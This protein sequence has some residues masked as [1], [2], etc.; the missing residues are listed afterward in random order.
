MIVS[1]P[2]PSIR[3]GA[4]VGATC[5]VSMAVGELSVLTWRTAVPWEIAA[6]IVVLDIGIL[7]TVGVFAARLSRRFSSM[8]LFVAAATMSAVIYPAAAGTL[9]RAAFAR[10]ALTWTWLPVAT[11]GSALGIAIVAGALTAAVLRVFIPT[12]ELQA[13]WQPWGLGCLVCVLAA[14]L[15]SLAGALHLRPLLSFRA[16]GIILLLILGS[17]AALQLLLSLWRFAPQRVTYGAPALALGV[18]SLLNL[19][20]PASL[21]RGPARP[22]ALSSLHEADG[23]HRPNIILI[24]LDTLR[25]D[26][27]SA[28]GYP[29]S[30]S[31]NLDQLAANAELYERAISPSTWTLPA[32]ASIFTGLSLRQ[33]GVRYRAGSG[34]P[35]RFV[36]L[37]TSLP[38]LAETLDRAGYSTAAFVANCWYLTPDV[39]LARGF[40]QYDATP[41]SVAFVRPAF[42]SLISALMPERYAAFIRPFHSAA[43]INTAALA[44]IDRDHQAPFFLFLN[45]ME[46]HWPYAAP[47]PYRDA[48]PASRGTISDFQVPWD[49]YQRLTDAV[50]NH[51]HRITP[52]EKEELESSYD[53]ALAHLD[54]ELGTFFDGLEQRGLYD[55]SVIIVTSD[56]GEL[57]GE[58]GLIGHGGDPYEGV[59]HVPLLI[60]YPHAEEG[61]RITK[62]ISTRRIF[63]IALA[64]AGVAAVAD[65]AEP[66]VSEV[67]TLPRHGA[68][69][70]G[71]RIRRALYDSTLKLIA[72]PDGDAVVYDVAAD[73]EEETDLLARSASDHGELLTTLDHWLRSEPDA[74]VPHATTQLDT[75]TLEALRALGYAR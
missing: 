19:D 70:T 6:A 20:W 54:H 64:H 22:A 44:W 39:G 21:L 47:P 67:Y 27:L 51:G 28:Y 18:M 71:H 9:M 36:T 14:K 31:P 58:H 66:V 33:H 57:F 45:Y 56:H 72:S 50:Q 16:V 63:S 68:E 2:R 60:R 17:L 74:P 62:P 69:P 8:A 32:H 48:F 52:T 49:P 12:R 61:R 37:S 59:T 38:T 3:D 43:E 11:L 75:A 1:E 55:R 24:V 25:A 4:A 46:M 26:H 53:A 40:S 10:G 7:T 30:T 41:R 5:G 23:Q 15:M 65:T 35:A 73:P 29:H 13:R 42:G 34:E